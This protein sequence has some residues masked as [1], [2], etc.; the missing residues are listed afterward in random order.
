MKSRRGDASAAARARLAE[1]RRAAGKDG[2]AALAREIG[3]CCRVAACREQTVEPG[4]ALPWGPARGRIATGEITEWAYDA[5]RDEL[6][7]VTRPVVRRRGADV[8]ARLA[9]ELQAVAG[10]YAALVEAVAA[11][12]APAMD[13]PGGNGLSDGGATSRCALAARLRA[14]RAAI[15]PGVALAP[16]NAE[17]HADRGR[18][19]ITTCALVDFVCVDGLALRHVLARFGWSRYRENEA[20]LAA[21]LLAALRRLEAVL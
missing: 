4:G 3:A 2:A 11:P 21:A 6:A 9:P 19:A 5:R 18:R 17:A 16:R 14:A 1:M 8:L 7:L 12:P 10:R 20:R 13:G 15:G